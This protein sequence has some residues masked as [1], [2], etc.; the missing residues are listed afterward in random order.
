MTLIQ[1][2]DMSAPRWWTP[3]GVGLLAASSLVAVALVAMPISAGA[4]AV[5][6]RSHPAAAV[7]AAAPLH[8]VAAGK[9]PLQGC[10]ES[11][12]TAT[13]DLYAM[14]GTNL[15]LGQPIPIWGFSSSGAAAS[16]TAPGPVLV[17]N[18]GD[19]VTVTLHNQ[20][21][22]PV[23]L[24]FPGQPASAFSAG[25]STVAEETGAAPGTTRAYTFGAGR[26]GTFLYEAGHTTDCLLYTS[27]SPRD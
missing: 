11:G 1:P 22:E 18:Q 24:A 12:T 3:R 20:L 9:L 23:S 10:T 27:P 7:A 8:A 5:Q 19:T 15:V 6:V 16:A 25:L 21:A 17:V 4:T 13:C 26:A 2:A 14:T